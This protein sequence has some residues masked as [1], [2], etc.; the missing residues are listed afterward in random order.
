MGQVEYNAFKRQMKQWMLENADLYDE[1]EE[2]MN[3]QSEIGVQ[4]VMAQA[5]ALVPEYDKVINKKINSGNADNADDAVALFA[6]KGVAVKL[7]EQFQGVGKKS[8]AAAMICWLFFGRSFE[9][10]VE[11]LERIEIGRAHV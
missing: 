8:I 7:I 11:N 2:M 6:E 3:S 4:Q 1:F 9:T 10:M 5:M